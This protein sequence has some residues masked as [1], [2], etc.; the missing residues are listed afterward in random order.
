MARTLTTEALVLKTYT[1]GDADLFCILLTQ[2]HG[3]VTATAKGV[4]K[5]GSKLSGALQTFQHV[6]L[7]LAEH[8]SGYYVRSANCLNSF[9]SIRSDLSQ[10]TLA[11]RGAELLLHFLHDTEPHPEIFSLAHQFFSE[12][13]KG[14]A[15]FLFEMFQ[16]MLMKELG[17]LPESSD[18][19]QPMSIMD[20]SIR[21]PEDTKALM[22]LCDELLREHLSF[23]LRSVGIVSL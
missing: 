3:R 7:D 23:P 16:L 19:P 8:T 14:E 2:S 15:S 5:L 10:F 6:R 13:E 11:S 4:R 1:I 9:S 20:H 18:V 12:C 21:V 17:I 22:R